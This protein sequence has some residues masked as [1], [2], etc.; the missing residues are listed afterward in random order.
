MKDN[1]PCVADNY[2]ICN[3]PYSL[4]KSN[5]A[6]NW[7]ASKLRAADGSTGRVTVQARIATLKNFFAIIGQRAS[8]GEAQTD[9][10]INRCMA[11]LEH[12]FSAAQ[13]RE[14]YGIAGAAR[15]GKKSSY[16]RVTIYCNHARRGGVVR[17]HRGHRLAWPV[18]FAGQG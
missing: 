11:N 9:E 15:G 16:G 17:G 14:Q 8:L 2:V 18:G 12:G 4:A 13:D 10:E 3:S 6:E 7:M 1:F 5:S